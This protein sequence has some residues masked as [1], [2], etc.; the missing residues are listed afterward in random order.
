MYQEGDI[1]V[2]QGSTYRRNGVS[3]S[4]SGY[5][6]P[7]ATHWEVVSAK[8]AQGEPGSNATITVSEIDGSSTITNQVTSVSAIRFDR[9]TGF[10]VEDLGE[11]EV[12]VSLGS[13][14]KTW[15]VAGQESLVAV[16]EDT[17]TFV[18]G[19]NMVISTD[20]NAKTITFDATSGGITV[21]TPEDYEVQGVATLAF[22]GAGVSVDRIDEITTVTIA[23]GS[24]NVD[25][26][27]FKI[28]SGGGYA[29]LSTTDDA[30]GNGGY[31]ITIN[32]NGEGSAFINIPNNAN[33]AQ[34]SALTINSFDSNSSVQ[35]RTD[36]SDPWIFGSDGTLTLPGPITVDA[37][38]TNIVAEFDGNTGNYGLIIL[39]EDYPTAN[40]EIQVG[41]TISKYND[42]AT[43]LVVTAAVTD[44]GTFWFVPTGANYIAGGTQTFNLSRPKPEWRFGANG[45]ITF[46]DATVQTTAFTGLPDLL[47]E[48]DEAPETGILWFNTQEARMYVKYNEQWVDASP[49]VLAP[50]DTNPT[51]ESVTFNDA[52]VQT[53]AWTGTVSY[54]DLTDKPVTPTFVGGGGA[55]TWL[56][57]D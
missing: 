19:N 14:W 2:H 28:D 9:D 8:G 12:K 51:L 11:G 46:P 50:P 16:G 4:I 42:P 43:L 38:Y 57:P 37:T 25:L 56:T 10:N 7:D 3:N 40:V 5:P 13:S 20:A 32:P 33:A 44:D 45:S 15:Q 27:K 1:V 52:T 21:I 22:A 18:A 26:G 31:N 36:W 54:N 55:S 24:G 6:P 30:N 35:V 23:G 49:T 53:T 39:K 48:S 34:G 41:D 29:Y 47:T 17:V